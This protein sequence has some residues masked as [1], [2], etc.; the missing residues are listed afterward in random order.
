MPGTKNDTVLDE[1]LNKYPL[2]DLW[3]DLLLIEGDMAPEERAPWMN[4]VQAFARKTIGREFS[5]TDVM[6][7]AYRNVAV[8]AMAVLAGEQQ[9]ND[10]DYED[11]DDEHEPDGYTIGYGDDAC[12]LLEQEDDD[13]HTHAHKETGERLTQCISCEYMFTQE[14]MHSGG[15]CN[16]CHAMNKDD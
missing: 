4:A 12:T 13:G 9:R 16:M 14:G 7:L 6:L 2:T 5:H 1:V 10:D 8:R 3:G 11:E 15:E